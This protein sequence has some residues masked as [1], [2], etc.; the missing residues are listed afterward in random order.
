M[1]ESITLENKSFYIFGAHPKKCD[2]LLRHPSI[3]RVH[4]AFVIDKENGVILVDLMSKA[5]TK[6]DNKVCEGCIPY[7]VKQG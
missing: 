4:S 5:S 1:I 7:T 6:L 3:S 2:V